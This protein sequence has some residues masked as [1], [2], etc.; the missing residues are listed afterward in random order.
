MRE[1]VLPAASAA[2]PARRA[3]R[4][5]RAFGALVALTTGLIVLGALVRAHGAGLACPDWPLCF[6]ELVPRF[7][8]HVAFEY[9]HRV[10][11]GAVGLAFVGLAA[12]A[13]RDERVRPRVARL[14]GAA[15]GLLALQ[16]VLGGLTVLH[17]LAAWTVTAHLVVGNS[18]NACLLLVA[19]RLRG[20][21]GVEPRGTRSEVPA[22]ARRAVALAAGLLGL[23]VVLGGLVSSTFAG[24]ACPEWPAC[25]GGHW[26]PAWRGSVGLHLAHR[27]NAYLLVAALAGAAWAARGVPRVGGLALLAAGLGL[28]QAAVGVANVLLGIPVEVT[29]LHSGLSALLVLALTAALEALGRSRAPAGHPSGRAA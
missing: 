27:W 25:N 13:L 21:A 17:L 8:F 12:V 9:A 14:V 3:E 15:A 11:A 23:Q 20:E 6:G 1:A 22:R 16:V 18:F 19:L 10:V 2:D 4:L 24:M 26:F 28:A 29:G 7:D 5:A